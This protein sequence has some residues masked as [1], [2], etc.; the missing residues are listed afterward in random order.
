MALHCFVVAPAGHGPKVAMLVA[1]AQQLGLSVDIVSGLESLS[2]QRAFSQTRHPLVL[3]ADVGSDCQLAADALQFAGSQASHAYLVY[4]SDSI[5]PDIYK[6][7]LRTQAA[8]WSKWELVSLELPDVI[9]QMLGDDVPLASNAK[10]LSFF[11]SKGGVGNTTLA[12]EVA[13]SLATMRSRRSSRIALL[14]LN[15]DGGTL[16]DA[17]DIEARFDL[18][19]IAGHPER[20]DNQLIDV[21]A[22]RHS[23]RLD[24]FATP[25]RRATSG[26]IAPQMIFTML[27]LLASRYDVILIDMPNQHLPWNHN[28]L[29]GSDMVILSGTSTVPALK[30]I[31]AKLALLDELKFSDGK[32]AVIV[33]Q[34]EKSLLGQVVRRKEIDRALPGRQLFFIRDDAATVRA[35]ANA[36]RPLIELSF[37]SHVSNDIRKLVGWIAPTIGMSDAAKSD[38]VR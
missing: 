11:P 21:F 34:C 23:D 6:Q 1:R 25:P 17:L 13:I 26:E 28:L 7:L 29:L 20:L 4:V 8:D 37:N 2:A 9:K 36:G 14:D 18:H 10:I 35:A 15:L 32:I 38:K 19:E 12:I 33:N 22:S 24:V 27:D 16:A 30:Q 3:L 5:D 31:H